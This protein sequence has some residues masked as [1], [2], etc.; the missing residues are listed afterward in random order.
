M[1]TDPAYNAAL[2]AAELGGLLEDYRGSYIMTFAAYNA[3]RRQPEEWIDRYGDPAIPRSTRSTGGADSV[4]GNPQLRAADHGE[5][6][7]IPARFGGGTLQIEADLHRGAS[8][9]SATIAKR[10]EMPRSLGRRSHREP[11]AVSSHP[12]GHSKR[13]GATK[14][15]PAVF[16]RGFL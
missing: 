7:G 2:G 13:L 4:L 6:A 8:V 10:A 1:K 11:G 12:C 5:P 14:K 16:R 15:T 3:G 9:N